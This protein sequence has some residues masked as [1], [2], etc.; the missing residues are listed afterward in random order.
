MQEWHSNSRERW[1]VAKPA[2]SLPTLC[3]FRSW[4]PAADCEW[5]SPLDPLE[6]KKDGGP[7][8]SR[9][10]IGWA[11]NGPLGRHCHYSQA[12]GFF[13]KADLQLQRM[14][15]E[16]Y[17]QDFTDSIINDKTEMSQDER[18]FMQSAEKSVELR[19]TFWNLFTIQKSSGPS[20]KQHECW[21]S[22]LDRQHVSSSLREEWKFTLSHVHCQP[23]CND[24]RWLNPSPVALCR[25]CSEP[26]WLCVKRDDHQSLD[27]LPKMVNG[28]GVPMEAG[29][30][31]ASGPFVSRYFSEEDPEV[32]SDGKVFLAS[33][34]ESVHPLVEYFHR[35]SS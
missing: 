23:N 10:R 11:V 34:S 33:I 3:P 8:A 5:L 28:V 22:I 9:T 16:F 1:S 30:R 26:Q 31:L 13:A 18:H 17:N 15:E 14:V 25:R 35:T 6:I 12:S 21:F 29:R 2:R 7:Y 19:W 24:M 20:T 27:D 32:K 4:S